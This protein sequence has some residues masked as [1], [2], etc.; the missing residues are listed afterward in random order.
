MRPPYSSILCATDLSPASDHAVALAYALA[1]SGAVVHLLY[2]D[3]PVVFAGPSDGP[4]VMPRAVGGPDPVA[5]E[6]KAHSRLRRLVPDDALTRGVRTETH[7][8]HDADVAA[9]IVAGAERVKADVVVMGTHGRTGF[10]RIL[11][12]SVAADVLKKE[13]APVILVHDRRAR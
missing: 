4:F 13:V 1:A 9:Q 10:G 11:M 3:E 2:V 7:V 5:V 8:M 12:G 6:K